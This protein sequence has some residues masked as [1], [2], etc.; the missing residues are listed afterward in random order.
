MSSYNT[1]TISNVFAFLYSLLRR[2][3]TQYAANYVGRQYFLFA[4]V[5][6]TRPDRIPYYFSVEGARSKSNPAGY[7]PTDISP[8][9]FKERPIFFYNQAAFMASKV[10]GKA[11]TY[12]INSNPPYIILNIFLNGSYRDVYVNYD[13]AK[14]SLSMYAMDTL[15]FITNEN[16][17]RALQ[18]VLND[19]IT[20]LSIAYNQ[21]KLL[22]NAKAQGKYNNDNFLYRPKY[23]A[24]VQ[25]QNWISS[26]QTDTRF[27][28][29]VCAECSNNASLG[30]VTTPTTYITMAGAVSL[31][32]LTTKFSQYDSVKNYLDE[33][34]IE[35]E[36]LR[37]DL[38]TQWKLVNQPGYTPTSADVKPMQTATVTATTKKGV[39]SWLWVVLGGAVL[40]SATGSNKKSDK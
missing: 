27:V 33:L 35:I 36:R 10:E 32:W 21:V 5:V 18:K 12:D 14:M 38:D 39:P 40:L 11:N 29:K 20:Q 7:L 37:V 4:N 24:K 31:T 9:Y 23:G 25:V 16:E 26:L 2:V 15:I 1:T 17:I 13:P 28:V 8:Y 6:L 34:L 30:D 19:V 22:E 3:Y